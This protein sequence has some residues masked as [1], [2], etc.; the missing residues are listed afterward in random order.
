MDIWLGIC[1][2][3]S[4]IFAFKNIT[5]HPNS[6]EFIEIDNLTGLASYGKIPQKWAGPD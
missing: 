2:E 1:R 3:A 4:C 5:E 6:I